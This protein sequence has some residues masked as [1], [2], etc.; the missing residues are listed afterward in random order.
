MKLSRLFGSVPRS[1]LSVLAV[2][3][4]LFVVSTAS[5]QTPEAPAPATL[6]APAPTTPAAPAAPIAEPAPPASATAYAAPVGAPAEPSVSTGG[7]TCIVGEHLGFDDADVRTTAILVCREV[8]RKKGGPGPYEIRFDKLGGRILFSVVDKQSGRSREMLIQ[9]IEEVPVVTSRLVGALVD[10]TPLQKTET[11]ENVAGLDTRAPRLKPGQTS[12]DMGI[13]GLTGIGVPFGASAGIGMGLNFRLGQFAVTSHGR[14]GGIGS[15]DN[16]VSSAALDVGG[17]Y[18]LGEEDTA[19]FAGGGFQF[20]YFNAVRDTR[21]DLDGSGLA[22]FGEVGVETM[23]TGRI[24]L[25]ASLRADVPF[26][27]LSRGP[28]TVYDTTS[29]TYIPTSG[30]SRYVVP[31]SLNLGIVFR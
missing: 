10:D 20:A 4:P 8:E 22:A 15:S 18:Y 19:L 6:P 2:A 17:R 5:A 13:N 21:R 7:T 9:S 12:F 28:D 1:S 14:L 11:V 24:G 23:R 25:I 29:R 27:D 31:L 26:F 30:E 16:K 3:A